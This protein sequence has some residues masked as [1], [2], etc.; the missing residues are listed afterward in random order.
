MIRW[1]LIYIVEIVLRL[2]V[3]GNVFRLCFRGPRGLEL[4]S[5]VVIEHDHDVV[6]VVIGVLG[7]AV[8]RIL[9]VLRIARRYA[10]HFVDNVF[11]YFAFR[12]I[13]SPVVAVR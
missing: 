11:H 4:M 2:E 6:S 1:G 9:A 8:D 10:D 5:L 7:R 3:I 13:D 12:C